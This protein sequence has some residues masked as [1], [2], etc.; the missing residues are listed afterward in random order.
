MGPLVLRVLRPYLRRPQPGHRCELCGGALPDGHGHV[1]EIEKRAILCA[2][3]ACA[4]LFRDPG[5]GGGRFRTVPD[6]IERVT[7]DVAALGIP[8]E[9]AWVIRHQAEWIATFP[10][11]AGPV[12]AAL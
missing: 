12:E 1:V 2:C 6:R 5:A 10:S 11:P 4:V 3:G 7:V 8:V 9:L